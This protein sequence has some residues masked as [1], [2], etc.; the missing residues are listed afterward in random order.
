MLS[1]GR[2]AA[3][4]QS[5]RIV[6][7]KLGRA[8]HPAVEGVRLGDCKEPVRNGPVSPNFDSVLIRAEEFCN[9]SHRQEDIPIADDFL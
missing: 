4:T 3:T 1:S 7:S 8:A 9:L 2:R 5:A 6:E